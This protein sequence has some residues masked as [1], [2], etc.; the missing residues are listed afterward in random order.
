MRKAINYISVVAL[1]LIPV[2]ALFPT[3][4]WPFNFPDSFFFPFITGKAFYFRI[5]VE[6]AFASWIILAFLDAKYRPR[7]NTLTIGVTVFALITLLA[8]LLGVNPLRSLWS[9]FE[10]MEGWITIFHLWMFFIVATAI[11]G[12]GEEG[13]K[14]WHRFLNAELAIAFIVG[15][16]GLSQLFGWTAIHQG[17]T[18]IDA[19]LG[20]AAYMAVYMLINAGLAVYLLFVTRIKSKIGMSGSKFLQW[21]YG[22]LAVLFSILTFETA[23]RGTILGLI[24]GIMLTLFLYAILA[25][26]KSKKSRWISVGAIGFIILVIIVFWFNRNAS[27]IQKSE[28][29]SRMA[30]ISW[31][32]A[33]G[34]AR[35]YVWPMAITGWSERPILGWGQENFNYIFN[36]NYNPKMWSQEQW[37]DRAHS[38]YFDW[39]TASGLVGLLAY[40][41]LYF[42]LLRIVWKSNLDITEKSVLIGLVVSYAIHNV[43]V[44]DNLA[45]Y[46]LFFTLLGFTTSFKKKDEQNTSVENRSIVIGGKKEFGAEII[47]YVV[48][49]VSI[50]VLIASI[51]FFNVRAIRANT[52]LIN[53]LQACGGPMPDVTLFEKALAIDVTV[54]NQE[55]REQILSCAGSFSQNQNTPGPTKQ[56][57]LELA[58]K[59]IENQIAA[60][61]KD[62]RMYVLGGHYLNSAGQLERAQSLLEEAHKLTPKKQ[63]ADLELA[64]NYFNTNKVEE[65]INLLKEAYE[66]D[67]TNPT[68][69][70][71]YATGLIIDGKDAE[72]KTIFKDNP[73]AY[74]SPQVAQVY[75]QLKRYSES[76]ALFKKLIAADPKNL[77]LRSTLAQ[78][79]YM[80]GMKS[81]AV[82]TLKDIEKDFPEYKDKIEAAIKQV[83]Q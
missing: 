27:F 33:Q 19:S 8:D 67:P 49:P 34:Q 47:E 55:I 50:V 12:Y 11:F 29:L 56:A 63:S 3:P 79:E 54:A 9:N 39:L 18:R 25:K 65:G 10:R 42:L 7:L 80:A 61:P 66:V 24:G 41:A 58:E 16:Y 32:E 20:N 15:C 37:F 6:I 71:A 57:F 59:S 35:N 72:V 62:A 22:I 73:S 14:M 68:T 81:A 13:K 53:S 26:D 2:F 4:I 48:M 83:Q 75:A 17:S 40:L 70:S 38:V 44:F 51:Y 76:I 46:I 45:S 74:E 64:I 30:N 1:F 43:F 5:L 23:T 36:A 60:S 28:V 82:Q 21:L 31:S 78:V 69:R 52:I 77:N